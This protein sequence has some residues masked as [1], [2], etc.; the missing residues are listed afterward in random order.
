MT[1][2]WAPTTSNSTPDLV[3]PIAIPAFDQPA[4]FPI[5]KGN[6]ALK[7]AVDK[8]LGELVKDGTWLKLYTQYFTKAPKPKDLPP[9]AIPTA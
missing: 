7:D 2:W 6:T 9:Y 8:A 3:Q 5:K 1:T 4:A